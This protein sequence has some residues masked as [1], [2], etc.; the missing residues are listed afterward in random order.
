MLLRPVLLLALLL[1]ASLPAGAQG[2]DAPLEATLEDATWSYG[3]EAWKQDPRFLQS[4]GTRLDAHVHVN[5]SEDD[6][7][8]AAT[9]TDGQQ[10][11]EG[12]VEDRGDG[13]LTATFDV[14]GHRNGIDPSVPPLV[15]GAWRLRIDASS[16]GVLP[17]QSEPQGFAQVT[18][19]AGFVAFEAFE[20]TRNGSEPAPLPGSALPPGVLPGLQETGGEPTWFAHPMLRIG[21][22][23]VATLG[24]DRVGADVRWTGWTPAPGLPT[25]PPFEAVDLGT[26]VTDA[27]G[28][29][30]LAVAATGT[31]HL[32]AVAAVLDDA[33]GGG[34]DVFALGTG[35][36]GPAVTGIA[37][38]DPGGMGPLQVTVADGLGGSVLALHGADSVLTQGPALL[39]M[40]SD[41]ALALLDPTPI[42]AA[43][44][45]DYRLLALADGLG[46]SYSG[47]HVVDRGLDVSLHVPLLGVGEPAPLTATF[48]NRAEAHGDGIGLTV[49]VNA[50]LLIGDAAHGNASFQVP[51]GGTLTRTW[52]W[53]PDEAG[54]TPFTLAVDTGDLRFEE[55][56]VETVLEPDAYER[57][58][59]PWYDP[60]RY[61]PGPAPVLAPLLLAGLALLLR[62]QKR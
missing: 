30:S 31:T 28:R 24:T 23:F 15:P 2:G 50:T 27:Q 45:P 54:S 7:T 25:G 55:R 5:T 46:L 57:E 38:P 21:D 17:G 22:A 10:T 18:V 12:R 40:G 53:T 43:A 14:D 59:A 32:M 4:L 9:L 13:R 41:T 48:T 61:T 11:L 37:S 56:A 20:R 26:T 19:P 35:D 1:V 44:V 36:A 29:T 39:P 8:Y 47:H 42:R 16:P 3:P 33:T 52:T 62:Q 60:Q 34:A 49:P 51:P 6:W 58:T